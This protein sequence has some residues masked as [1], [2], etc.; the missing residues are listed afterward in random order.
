MDNLRTGYRDMEKRQRKFDQQLAEE[1]ANVQKMALERDS[2]A[3]DSRDRE[4]KILSL[5]NELETF[6][7]QFEESE[8]TR[9]MLQ[10]ELDESVSTKD[11]VGK[12]V[13]AF[14]QTFCH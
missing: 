3:Q 11:D 13:R 14:N 10:I 1:R 4:T 7:E 12:S 2:H 9:R 6:R 8:R 5:I